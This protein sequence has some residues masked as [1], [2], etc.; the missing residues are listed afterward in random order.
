MIVVCYWSKRTAVVWNVAN[1]I[2]C[3]FV[4]V[5]FRATEVWTFLF[6]KNGDLYCIL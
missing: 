1:I 2:C 3:R 5:D 4:H 6:S